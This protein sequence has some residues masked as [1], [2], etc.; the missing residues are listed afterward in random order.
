MILR[1]WYRDFLDQ[2]AHLLHSGIPI[3]EAL[4]M[5]ARD[6]RGAR[7]RFATR[8]RDRVVQGETL[9][10]AFAGSP[11]PSPEDVALVDAGERSGQLDR[12]L[13]M[14]VQR[15]ERTRTL[16]L[17]LLPRITY[18]LFLFAAASILLPLPLVVLGRV[19]TYFAIQLCTFGPAVAVAFVALRFDALFPPGT[20]LRDSIER[21]AART[22]W[23]GTIL[24]D[25][26]C[27]KVFWL[28]GA[29][30]QAG[31]PLSESLGMASRATSV[32][33]V[34]K[35]F[36]AVEPRIREG[37][38]FV[39]A[40][41]ADPMFAAHADWIAQMNVGE[42]SGTLDDSCQKL[43]ERLERTAM[44][45]LGRGLAVLPYIMIPMVGAGVLYAGLRVILQV[46]GGAL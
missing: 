24:V 3:R 30:I 25:R 20:P 22:R 13:V 10:E 6:A 4:D 12:V 21:T 29:M 18:P 38:N 44:A 36:A 46:Y 28:L 32:R 31:I 5:L 14:M 23:V 11:E 2:L 15:I 41:R 27:G 26:A 1:R 8:C 34:Q 42:H 16:V 17:D 35:A 9:A 7:G 43:G 33:N 39:E 40:L 45:R 19:A 37:K